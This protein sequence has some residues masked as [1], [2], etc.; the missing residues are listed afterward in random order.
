MSSL[1]S[2]CKTEQFNRH[3]SPVVMVTKMSVNLKT[4]SSQKL[5]DFDENEYTYSVFDLEQEYV[6]SFLKFTYLTVKISKNPLFL[7]YCP[8]LL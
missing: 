8:I 3:Q 5:S 7:K 2:R 1:H 6:K 4:I